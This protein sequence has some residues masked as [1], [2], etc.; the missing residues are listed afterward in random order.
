MILRT[1]QMNPL[2]AAFIAAGLDPSTGRP[3]K[4]PLNGGKAQFW[5]VFSIISGV[6]RLLVVPP[7]SSP[8]IKHTSSTT[9][10]ADAALEALVRG[11]L[12]RPGTGK[13]TVINP[14]CGLFGIS[15]IFFIQIN[16]TALAPQGHSFCGNKKYSLVDPKTGNSQRGKDRTIPSFRVRQYSAMEHCMKLFPTS[17]SAPLPSSAGFARGG[18]GGAVAGGGAAVASPH[19]GGKKKS[20]TAPKCGH[21]LCTHLHGI[22]ARHGGIVFPFFEYHCGDGSK[23]SVVIMGFENGSWNL[24]C[25]EMEDKDNGCWILTNARALREKGKIFL[26]RHLEDSDIRLGNSIHTTPV[27]YVQLDRSMVMH[28]LSRGVLNAQVAADNSNPSLPS[29]YKKIQAIGFFE[30]VGNNLVPLPGNPVGYPNTFSREV[31]SWLSS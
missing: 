25:E 12:V 29:C 13:P 16:Q 19:H 5:F 8:I 21:A 15:L 9:M 23:K 10:P 6:N 26:L 2:K 18:G 24:L 14:I 22:D 28:D 4:L 7:G 30:R 20:H 17:N 3:V 31:Q 27:F 1:S 11:G